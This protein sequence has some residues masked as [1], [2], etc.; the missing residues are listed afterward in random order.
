MKI[1]SISEVSEKSWIGNI[2]N[3]GSYV[4]RMN[5][6]QWLAGCT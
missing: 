4:G 1:E 2:R 6:Y 5:I 3:I